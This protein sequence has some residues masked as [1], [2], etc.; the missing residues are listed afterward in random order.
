MNTLQLGI[1][2]L[3]SQAITESPISA[4]TTETEIVLPTDEQESATDPGQ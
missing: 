1:I 3:R 2:Y 4:I